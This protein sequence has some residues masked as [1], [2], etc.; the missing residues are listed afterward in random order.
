M[1]YTPDKRESWNSFVQKSKNGTFLLNRNYMDYHADR[2]ADGSLMLYRNRQ[3]MA[4]LP[5]NLTGTCFYSHQGLT[6]GGLILPPAATLSQ[7]EYAFRLSLEYLH[8]HCHLTAFVY[9]AIPHI[10]HRYPAEEDLYLLN[11]LG[12]TLKA[13]H[14]SSVVPAD[15][16]LPFRTLRR[17]QS[18][19][20]CNRH[21]ILVNDTLF[22]PYWDILEE[23]LRTRHGVAPVH[24]LEEITLLRRRFPNN[25]AL[26]RVCNDRQ[27]T[28]AGCVVYETDTV[29]H[30]QYIAS[31]SQGRKAGALDLL[32]D[33]LIHTRYADKR[34]FDF[35]ISTEQDGQVLNEGLLF[36]KEGFG[37]RAVMYDTY[38]LK[39]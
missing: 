22:A 8:D 26:Y 32:F 4:L 27:A 25:I 14:L 20:A 38:E 15:H 6:Y 21:L 30:V 36:Q 9:R 28:L 39:L 1:T 3:L 11:R 7:A 17:R 34:Y 18:K 10:Y 29:A 13:R 23:N 2:F 12:A 24:T 16:R 31:S 33:D 37:A 19:R 35:G 5:G